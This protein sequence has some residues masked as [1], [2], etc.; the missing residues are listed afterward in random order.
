MQSAPIRAEIL[1]KL[2]AQQPTLHELGI[3]SLQLFGSVAR[4]E[5]TAHSDIDCLVEFS[6]PMGLFSVSKIKLFL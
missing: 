5:V 4:D 1:A 3:A 6:R 2:K